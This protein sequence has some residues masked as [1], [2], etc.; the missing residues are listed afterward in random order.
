MPPAGSPGRVAGRL[1]EG[2]R[3]LLLRAGALVIAAVVR[4]VL[5]LLRHVRAGRGPPAAGDVPVRPR[6]LAVPGRGAVAVEVLRRRGG[7]AARG[8]G[9][10]PA[11]LRVGAAGGHV[12]GFADNGGI[13]DVGPGSGGGLRE[14]SPA[15]ARGAGAGR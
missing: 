13:G 11:G 6:G 4:V 10:D 1:L 2:Q 5:L 9:G 15:A 3:V 12:H 14:L 7:E 8:R